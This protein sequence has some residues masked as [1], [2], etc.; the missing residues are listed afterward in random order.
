MKRT[1]KRNLC[2]CRTTSVNLPMP[3]TTLLLFSN[4]TK[5][6]TFS[7]KRNLTKKTWWSDPWKRKSKTLKTKTVNCKNSGT[8]MT[9]WESFAKTGNSW[10]KSRKPARNSM[11]SWK[12]N[13]W[14]V[15]LHKEPLTTPKLWKYSKEDKSD[16]KINIITLDNDDFYLSVKIKFRFKALW[17]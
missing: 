3:T 6:T 4:V 5:S 11:K 7:S 14:R 9:T 10:S 12:R 1:C 13:N 2:N 15:G 16:Y 8:K 17:I